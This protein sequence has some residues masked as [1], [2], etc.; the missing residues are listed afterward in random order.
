MNLTPL[1]GEGRVCKRGHLV[2]GDNLY[3]NPTTG[4]T[5]C[6]RCLA[7]RNHDYRQ[8]KAAAE[9]RE[10]RGPNRRIADSEPMSE[11]TRYRRRA[12]RGE[13]QPVFRYPWNDRFF[14]QWSDPMAWVLGLIW[15]DGYLNRSNG[16]EVCSKDSVLI[17]LI[18]GLIEQPGG[19]RP[20]NG[21]AHL[22]IF[23]SSPHAAT[24]L[25]SL[26]LTTSKSFTI[27]WPVG[28]P[29]EY[30]GA[31]VRGLIDGDGSVLEQHAR[32]GQQVTDLAVS[33]NSASPAL[34]DSVL[35][36][37]RRHDLR[38]GMGRNR[39]VFRLT[40][41]HQ[42]SLR[43]LHGLLYPDENACCLFRKRIPYDAWME[44]PR[45]RP[46]RPSRDHHRATAAATRRAAI[47]AGG[48][49]ALAEPHPQRLTDWARTT[50]C[51]PECQV[52]P[53]V[54]CHD[55]GRERTTV[56]DRRY[57]EAEETCS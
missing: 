38:A 9:G 18:E 12:E 19:M 42:E 6:R 54:P 57:Q 17:E 48:Q 1:S 56:H 29:E 28:L 24:R 49:I 25:R 55:E 23:F 39:S 8:R 14:D 27:G 5:E 30:E 3:A 51:C 15:S 41:T 40:I 21:G 4:R 34:V 20:K 45:A 52:E 37:F 11:R 43:R 7:L 50:A 10:L 22:R 16:V 44:T 47:E 31:F 13:T 36:W 32:P 35:A 53:T 26:G 33:F 2:A 46:G